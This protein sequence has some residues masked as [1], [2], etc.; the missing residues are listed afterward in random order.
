LRKKRISE[1]PAAAR[2]ARMAFTVFAA[3]VGELTIQKTTRIAT[4]T[5]TTFPGDTASPYLHAR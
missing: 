5:P 3:V 2:S 1:F 4:S